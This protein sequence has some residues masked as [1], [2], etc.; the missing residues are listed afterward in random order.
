M[1][2]VYKIL[3]MTIQNQV[4]LLPCFHFVLRCHISTKYFGSQLLN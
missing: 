3:L 2:A 1:V 4:M